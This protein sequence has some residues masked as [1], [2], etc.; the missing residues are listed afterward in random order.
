MLFVFDCHCEAL[1]KTKQLMSDLHVLFLWIFSLC[2]MFMFK[3]LYL[4]K[5]SLLP[6]VGEGGR[7][8]DDDIEIPFA[9]NR[10]RKFDDGSLYFKLQT[11]VQARVFENENAY[12]L[13]SIFLF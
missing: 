3:Q 5:N 12:Y 4:P 7:R 6:L 11:F 8:P 1:C 2:K 9:I 10:R 13:N